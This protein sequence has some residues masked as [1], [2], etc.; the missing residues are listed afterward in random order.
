MS[1]VRRCLSLT[2]APTVTIR[3]DSVRLSNS[4]SAPGGMQAAR[5]RA[6]Q[7]AVVMRCRVGQ[8]T[9]ILCFF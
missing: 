7:I 4:A 5:R 8:V 3:A 6:Y 2:I 1:Q 9:I